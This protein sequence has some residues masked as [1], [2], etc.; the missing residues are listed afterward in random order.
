MKSSLKFQFRIYLP[1]GERLTE[2]KI[3]K[4]KAAA[5]R[6]IARLE[7]IPGG[8]TIEDP[9][10]GAATH[11]GDTLSVLISA[12]CLTGLAE[13]KREGKIRIDF[14][15]HDEFVDIELADDRVSLSGDEIA[16]QSYPCDKYM[17]AAVS[18]GE[19]YVALLREA[20]RGQKQHA[21]EIAT[22]EQELAG[23]K[24]AL[25]TIPNRKRAESKPSKAGTTK[26]QTKKKSK[27]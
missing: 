24:G 23:A 14:F 21:G 9:G 17:A 10:R 25:K 7:D 20:W 4:N 2:E 22:L 6:A 8:L 13:L 18:C 12:F 1:D 3:E 11:L 16:P 26:N 27:R 19:R 15:D 5:C